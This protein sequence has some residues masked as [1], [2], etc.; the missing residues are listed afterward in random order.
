MIDYQTF[1]LTICLSSSSREMP[2]VS[3]II[4][5]TNINCSTIMNAKNAKTDPGPTALNKYGTKDGM[6]AANTQCTELPKAWP[7]ARR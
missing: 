4:F 2:L 6:I 3:G 1:L 5:H 7:F